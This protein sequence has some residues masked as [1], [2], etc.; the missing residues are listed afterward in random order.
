MHR[1]S[2]F[3]QGAIASALVVCS[4]AFTGSAVANAL[5]GPNRDD[6]RRTAIE[7]RAIALDAATKKYRTPHD[8]NFPLRGLLVE[9]TKREDLEHHPWYTYI[10]GQNGNLVGYYITKTTPINACDFLSGTEDIYHGGNSDVKMT[11][12]SLDGIFYGGGGSAAACDV[13]EAQDYATGAIIKFKAPMLM[14]VDRPLR[15]AAKPILV[16]SK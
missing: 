12:P 2:G 6:Q 5:R 9:V 14:S 11:A 7:D 16:S 4:I 15:I 3:F 13:Y 1:L 8:V 10:M